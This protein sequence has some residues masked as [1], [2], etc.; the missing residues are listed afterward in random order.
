MSSFACWVQSRQA[1]IRR[2]GTRY[3]RVFGRPIEV[4]PH[5]GAMPSDAYPGYR[6][7]ATS[8]LGGCRL[9]RL[10]PKGSD[11]AFEFFGLVDGSIQT[12]IRCY[13]NE[14]GVVHKWELFDHRSLNLSPLESRNP[15]DFLDALFNEAACAGNPIAFDVVD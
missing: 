12:L 11:F 2:H 14:K 3:L 5:L 6:I 13:C 4:V 15:R 1:K 10:W 7:E 9:T 8:Y